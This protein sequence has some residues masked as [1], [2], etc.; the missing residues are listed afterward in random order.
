MVEVRIHGRGGQGVVTASDLLAMAAY[1]DGHHAQAFPSF[2]SER[3]G[4]PVVSF[5]RITQSEIRTR[6]PVLEPDVI[7]VQDPTLL[8]VM[9]VFAGIKPNGYVLV[10]STKSF[11]ELG[12]GDM[13]NALPAGHAQTIPAFDIAKEFVGRPVPNAVM[14]GGFAALTGLIRLESV[15]GAIRSRFPGRVGEANIAAATHTFDLIAQALGSTQ[16][17]PSGD[18]DQPK[19][20]PG[21][22]DTP[23]GHE[24]ERTDA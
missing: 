18:A 1:T 13:V 2:G 20:Q 17:T 12:L 11:T 21:D 10:N 8:P 24:Q 23:A 19:S 9:D 14:L 4:A 5:C 16:E 6:E 7:I 22:H 15:V 3:M